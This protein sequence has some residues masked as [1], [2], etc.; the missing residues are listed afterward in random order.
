MREPRMFKVGVFE[1]RREG[2]KAN[3]EP[4]RVRLEAYTV[5][6]SPSWDGC[7]QHEVTARNGTEAK[8]NAMTAHRDQCMSK[9]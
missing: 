6:Y 3:G 1:H 9:A 2:F 8:A 5:W 7:C 4:Y